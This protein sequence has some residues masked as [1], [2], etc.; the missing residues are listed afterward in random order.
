MR[1][2]I[3]IPARGSTTTPAERGVEYE[4]QVT[5]WEAAYRFPKKGARA[6]QTGGPAGSGRGAGEGWH[7]QGLNLKGLGL[8]HHSRGNEEVLNELR[9]VPRGVI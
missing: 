3:N 8:S 5:G 4:A 7:C 9:R 2:P 6:A 1:L